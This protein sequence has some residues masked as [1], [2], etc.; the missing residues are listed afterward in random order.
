MA[1]GWVSRR[2]VVQ[3]DSHAAEPTRK[4]V[5]AFR[6]RTW[7]HIGNT[8]HDPPMNRGIRASA[9]RVPHG[10][11]SVIKATELEGTFVS[12]LVPVC[13]RSR[14]A[15]DRFSIRLRPWRLSCL[16]EREAIVGIINDIDAGK[17]TIL[18][19]SATSNSTS[20]LH[21]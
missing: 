14:K 19:L 20:M 1:N 9:V 21:D 7:R 6:H 11:T 18:A 3:S 17:G 5:I 10:R 4:M 12:Q 15:G 2:K 8:T 13:H 16:C